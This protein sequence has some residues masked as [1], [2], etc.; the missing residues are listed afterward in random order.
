MS[1]ILGLEGQVLGLVSQVLGLECQ[2]LDLGLEGQVLVNNTVWQKQ[3]L[4]YQLN[5]L[6]N[7]KLHTQ[8]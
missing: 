6:P 2:I 4:C 3:F 5:D 8:L 7:T 1:Q